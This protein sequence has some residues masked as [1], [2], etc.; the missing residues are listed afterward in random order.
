MPTESQYKATK[1]YNSEHY[2]RIEIQV[3]KGYR[4]IYKEVARS[5]GMSVS[6]YLNS[7]VKQDM[8]QS[9]IKIELPDD[10]EGLKEFK[11]L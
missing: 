2:D 9:A 10:G 8:K 7:L 3:K 4:K 6:S 11:P 5:K 1:K